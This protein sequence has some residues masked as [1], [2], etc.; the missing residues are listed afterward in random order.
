MLEIARAFTKLPAP[1]KRSILFLSVT[2]EEQGLLGSEWL[3]RHPPIPAEKIAADI[4]LDSVNIWGRTTDPEEWARIV[5][6][7]VAAIRSY[8]HEFAGSPLRDL[9]AEVA[10][11]PAPHAMPVAP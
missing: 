7:Q 3:S 8:M 1:P 4:N 6:Q 5:I 2:A 9:W 10:G 11:Q